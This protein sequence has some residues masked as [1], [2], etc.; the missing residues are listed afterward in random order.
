MTTSRTASTGTENGAASS[1]KDNLLLNNR[2]YH[3]L[4]LLKPFRMVLQV[5]SEADR[6][7][8]RHQPPYALWGCGRRGKPAT[9]GQ[10]CAGWES[11]GYSQRLGTPQEEQRIVENANKLLAG[12]PVTVRSN[13]PTSPMR[14]ACPMAYIYDWVRCLPPL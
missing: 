8:D 1:G 9:R 6:P 7:V 11:I 2:V 14:E 4:W 3:K 10:L 13:L 5:S 12:L